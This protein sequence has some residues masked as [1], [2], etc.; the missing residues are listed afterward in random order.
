MR[1]NSH[2]NGREIR[3][4]TSRRKIMFLSLKVK[5]VLAFALQKNDTIIADITRGID[6]QN[7]I[8]AL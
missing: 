5:N 8:Q 2:M 3:P 7:Q 1:D 4:F 6:D